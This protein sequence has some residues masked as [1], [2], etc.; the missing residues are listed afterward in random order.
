MDKVE[1]VRSLVGEILNS[2]NT[3]HGMEHVERVFK[4]SLRFAREQSVDMDIVSLIALLHDVDDYKIFGPEEAKNLT[5]ARE[6]LNKC[7]VD[8]EAK[9]RIVEDISTIG[10][11]KR[12]QGVVPKTNEAKIVSDADM[13]DAMGATGILRSYQYNMAHGRPFFDESVLPSLDLSADEYRAKKDGTVVTHIFEKL[14]RLKGLML[15]EPG[16]VEAEKRHDF[17][18]KFLYQFFAEENALEWAKYLDEYLGVID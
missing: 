4:L 5:H 17:M 3:G 15:T 11:S 13:C 12:L 10:Y 8:E 18:V 14:L 16:R 2:D 6:I 7:D 9:E 1:K